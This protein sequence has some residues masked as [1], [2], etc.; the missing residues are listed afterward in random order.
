VKGLRAEKYYFS[1]I[2][3]PCFKSYYIYTYIYRKSPP[4]TKYTNHKILFLENRLMSHLQYI[5]SD[6]VIQT[7]IQ[8]Q[9]LDAIVCKSQFKTKQTTVTKQKRHSGPPPPWSST[10]ASSRFFFHFCMYERSKYTI[11]SYFSI[12]KYIFNTHFVS[13][14]PVCSC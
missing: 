8:S 9:K 13:R 3:Y 5:E 14:C 7:T 1:L 11:S 6:N 4:L 10:V 2:I 12:R